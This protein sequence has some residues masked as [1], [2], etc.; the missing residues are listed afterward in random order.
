MQHNTTGPEQEPLPPADD[1]D[2]LERTLQRLKEKQE[3]WRKLLESIQGMKEG[4]QEKPES[5]QPSTST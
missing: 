4:S 5:E 2:R 3:A 1:L